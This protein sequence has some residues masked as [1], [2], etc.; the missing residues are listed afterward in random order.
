M[1]YENLRPLFEDLAEHDVYFD[2]LSDQTW[3]PGNWLVCH[4][5]PPDHFGRPVRHHI[6]Q[7]PAV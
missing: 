6:H 2:A 4:V 3:G 5:C 7:H 1:S